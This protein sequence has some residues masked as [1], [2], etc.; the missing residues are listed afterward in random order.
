MG[1]VEEQSEGAESAICV[2]PS[3]DI[4]GHCAHVPVQRDLGAVDR[5][6]GCDRSRVVDSDDQ[7]CPENA[8][9]KDT[10]D[11]RR[12]W[13]DEGPD[14]ACDVITRAG[15]F[16]QKLPDVLPLALVDVMNRNVRV[17]HERI[18]SAFTMHLV[19]FP[20]R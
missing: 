1:F 9:V 4:A 16:C 10:D 7:A 5:C 6:H 15:C 13:G 8:T 18:G 20:R 2:D 17:E 12:T 3:H 14:S 19:F 11:G